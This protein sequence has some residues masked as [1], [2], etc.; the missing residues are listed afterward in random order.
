MNQLVTYDEVAGFLKNHPTM[1][2]R[3]DF[4]KIRA[5][6]KHIMQALKQLDCLQSLIYGWA[7]LTMDLTMYALIK[8]NM[9]VQPPKPGDSPP[10]PQ[11]ATPQVLKTC[12]R[13]WENARNYY[14]SYVNISSVCF[15]MLDKLVPDQYKVSN[16]PNLLG[17]NPTMSI[18]LIL[19]QL[20][21]SYGKP[22][23]NI[24]WNNNIL[25]TANSNPV[26]APETLFHQIKQCPEVAIIGATP[27]TAAQLE[28]NMMH[29]FLKSGIFP[30]REFESCDAVP[31]KTWPVL[32]TF[33]HGVYAQKLVALNIH[34]TTGQQGYIPQNMYHALDGGNN[35]S[36]TNTTVTQTAAA[37]TTGST[38]GNTYQAT[39]IPPE[40]MAAINTIT[41]NQQSLYQHIALL[42]Q[43]MAALSFHVQPPTQARQLALHAPPVQH[44]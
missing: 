6:R 8:T 19:A 7:R 22:M 30:T 4:A 20:E 2:P 26:D 28:N 12:K 38:L 27:Y 15:R 11:F 14:L 17:W 32:K 29:L 44:I 42:S 1:L 36:N 13:L 37:A 43:Q 16:D 10:Y 5:L 35:T 9:F 24:I 18:Q 23:A 21:S 34:N 3:P 33:V 41:A 25:F 40:L 39:A 31:N